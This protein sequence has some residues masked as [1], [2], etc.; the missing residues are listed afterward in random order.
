MSMPACRPAW[1]L[2]LALLAV[3]VVHAQDN[4]EARLRDALRDTAAKLHAT[5]A[6][7]EQQQLATAAAERERDALKQ[8]PRPARTDVAQSAALQRKLAASAG[9][10]AQAS[11]AVQKWQ[12]AQQASA[13]ALQLKEAER[14]SLAERLAQ[15]R[16]RAESC[17]ANDDAFYA[18]GREIA[19]LYR[20]PAFV[21]YFTYRRLPLGFDRVREEN[22]VR[23]LEDHLSDQL[24]Q[25]HRCFIDATSAPSAPTTPPSPLTP[26]ERP[27]KPTPQASSSQMQQ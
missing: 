1:L 9:E 11:V 17:V 3:S 10:L 4:T 21:A 5:E 13:Q 15:L 23:A 18:T 27:G 14:A 6:E 2:S 26:P 8:A 25:Q 22:R 16:T 7:L 12:A 24:A 19:A 20:D